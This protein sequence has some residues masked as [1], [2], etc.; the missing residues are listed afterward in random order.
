MN[1]ENKN[2]L[3]VIAL[4]LSTLIG[5]APSQPPDNTMP[6]M[7]IP[8]EHKGHVVSNF[9]WIMSRPSPKMHQ[10]VM[11]TP[12]SPENLKRVF[13]NALMF[14]C[15]ASDIRLSGPSMLNTLLVVDDLPFYIDSD[16][17]AA[18]AISMQHIA[19]QNK[20]KALFLLKA[21]ADL[22]HF[23]FQKTPPRD[24]NDNGKPWSKEDWQIITEET[25]TGWNLSCSFLCVH[26]P[27]IIR[28]Y[29]RYK[30]YV[31]RTG[32]ISVID[33]SPLLEEGG[34]M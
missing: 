13:P 17:S 3:V 18:N 34:Y 22:R 19:V 29:Y 26:D 20:E 11:V 16:D 28:W 2:R 27:P 23:I 15:F 1:R 14:K 25:P 31:D 8:F 10:L 30:I 9:L 4:L 12:M 6:N 5:C 21:F 24:L 7:T 32:T 33:R